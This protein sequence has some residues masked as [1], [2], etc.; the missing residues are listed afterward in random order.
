VVVELG[1]MLIALLVQLEIVIQVVQ[2]EALKEE[3]VI[4]VEQEI[5]L[6]LVHHK[7]NQVVTLV[8]VLI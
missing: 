8:L 3:Q 7:V 6:Q 5:L 2:A 4:Q 1:M